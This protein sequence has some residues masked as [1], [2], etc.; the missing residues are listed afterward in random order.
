MTNKL[1]DELREKIADG[2]IEIN[3]RETPWGDKEMT[4]SDNTSD[5]YSISSEIFDELYEFLENRRELVLDVNEIESKYDGIDRF[6][7]LGR[8]ANEYVGDNEISNG[9]FSLVSQIGSKDEGT[10][11]GQMRSI[12]ET[13][14]NQEY[15]DEY[16]N[17][18]S[19]AELMQIEG[20]D[21]TDI[22]KLNK[23]ARDMD[24]YV[25]KKIMR[26]IRYILRGDSIE[27]T[28]TDC[29]DKK[30]YAEMN[31]GKAINTIYQTHRLME[32]D[33]DKSQIDEQVKS[34]RS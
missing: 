19:L 26:T 30:I 32:L 24:L 12:A 2:D 7:H 17:P 27:E 18:S 1:P 3:V 29:M 10:F 5:K 11:V 16:F 28:V 31:T 15:N 9:E 20:L 25:D 33:V 13:F 8:L 4:V 22:R 14:P 23:N 21:D 34:Y 6:W